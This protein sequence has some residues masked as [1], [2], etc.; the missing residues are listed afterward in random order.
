MTDHIFIVSILSLVVVIVGFCIG[1]RAD[2]LYKNN[3]QNNLH[4]ESHQSKRDIA[5]NAFLEGEEFKMF[6]TCESTPLKIEPTPLN[7]MHYK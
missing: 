1:Y 3:T 6:E 2:K 7:L 4:S 5:L